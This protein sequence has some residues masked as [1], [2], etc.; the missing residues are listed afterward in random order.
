MQYKDGTTTIHYET[1]KCTPLA[2]QAII[3]HINMNMIMSRWSQGPAMG[4][5]RTRT[6]LQVA[7]N[8][9][10]HRP[11][12]SLC[13]FLYLSIL[14]IKSRPCRYPDHGANHGPKNHCIVTLSPCT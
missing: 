12:F 5:S 7:V 13:L 3:I 10:L 14:Q 8:R 1:R 4:N 2:K 6:G 9:H 11:L